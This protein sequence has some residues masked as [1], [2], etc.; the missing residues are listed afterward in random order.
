MPRPRIKREP[1]LLSIEGGAGDEGGGSGGTGGGAQPAAGA[2]AAGDDNT[3]FKEQYN[4]GF[5]AALKFIESYVKP[6]GMTPEQVQAEIAKLASEKKKPSYN[7][8]DSEALERLKTL[9]LENQTLKQAQAQAQIRNAFAS[10]LTRAMA[11]DPEDTLSAIEAKFEIRTVDGRELIYRKGATIPETANGKE[12]TVKDFIAKY[13][14]EKPHHFRQ[15]GSGLET[16][17]DTGNNGSL[18]T[19]SQMRDQNFVRALK[20]TGQYDLVFEKKPVDMKRIRAYM[21][22][23]K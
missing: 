17:L 6:G 1:W 4:A 14:A 11:I 13:K 16:D 2:G 21:E 15:G 9:E 7:Q 22:T 10:E 19:E 3:K 20:G 12:A 18:V 23:M 5:N 8:Q